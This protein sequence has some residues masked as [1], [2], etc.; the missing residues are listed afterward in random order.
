MTA[1]TNP[2]ASDQG[3]REDTVEFGCWK[4]IFLCLILLVAIGVGY[5]VLF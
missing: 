3:D 4:W 5:L 2:P 1:E